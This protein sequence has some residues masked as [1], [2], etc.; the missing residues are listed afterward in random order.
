MNAWCR[1]GCGVLVVLAV[2]SATA[3]AATGP[4]IRAVDVTTQP[5]ATGGT[6]EQGEGVPPAASQPA[7]AATPA[8]REKAKLLREAIRQAEFR[9][10]HVGDSDKPFYNV[11]LSVPDFMLDEPKPFDSTER[12]TAA[13]GE[14]IVE[15]LLASGRLN[16]AEQVGANW[17]AP[18]AAAQ[19]YTLRIAA[20]K[21]AFGLSL[22]WDLKMVREL[23]A[24][25]A[26]LD[27]DA[28]LAM[29]QLLARMSGLRKQWEAAEPKP[30]TT[31]PDRAKRLVVIDIGREKGYRVNGTAVETLADLERELRA[32]LANA[33]S[34]LFLRSHRSTI[35]IRVQEVMTLAAKLKAADVQLT[36]PLDEDPLAG[37]PPTSQPGQGE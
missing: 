11:T 2:C 28:A 30:P 22:G 24:I 3:A 25:R 17:I 6:A 5:D 7:D 37:P 36:A 23:D 14:K 26:V 21:L 4:A 12:I 34:V 20:G 10:Q 29:D 16:T 8:A 27:G 18:P 9:F 13:Q 15:L 32:R 35:W 33:H 31:Q 1:A 19:G